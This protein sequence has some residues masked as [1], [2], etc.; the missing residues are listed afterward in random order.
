MTKLTSDA[1]TNLVAGASYEDEFDIALNNDLS[2]GGT[3]TIYSEGYVN[4]VTNGSVS[5]TMPYSSNE[6]TID[7]DPKQAK[8]VSKARP[9]G[10]ARTITTCS[11]DRQAIVDTVLANTVKL[12]NAAA[13]AA[14]SGDAAQ[15]NYYFKT[16]A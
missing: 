7:I 10:K 12:A 4:L 3:V 2:E 11:P 15:F 16:T 9:M 5:G 1:V 8:T 13:D 14:T 6:L